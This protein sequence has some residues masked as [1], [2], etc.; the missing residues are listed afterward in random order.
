MMRKTAVKTVCDQKNSRARSRRPS[1][2]GWAII[3]WKKLSD[4]LRAAAANII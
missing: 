4:A 3:N 1:K 2:H